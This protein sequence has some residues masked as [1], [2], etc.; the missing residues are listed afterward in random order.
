MFTS[1]NLFFVLIA[2]FISFLRVNCNVYFSKP[3]LRVNCNAYFSKPFLRVNCNVYFSKPFLRVNCNVYFSKPFL[4][5]NCNV[6]FS[7]PFL[8]V[9]CNVYF[10]SS[11][12]L[13]CLFLK[14]VWSPKFKFCYKKQQ[15][16]KCGLCTPNVNSMS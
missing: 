11:C 16:D 10:F 14:K 9:N 6:Y 8:R 15:R 12:Q 3:V 4:R 1:L 7:K 2:M 5:V 13:Q